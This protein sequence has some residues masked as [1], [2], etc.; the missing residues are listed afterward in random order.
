MVYATNTYGNEAN[1]T[2]YGIVVRRAA[3]KLLF[4]PDGVEVSFAF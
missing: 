2:S 3:E 1:A 4:K